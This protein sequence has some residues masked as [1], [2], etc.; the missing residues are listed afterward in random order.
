MVIKITKNK[1]P[2]AAVLKITNCSDDI[3]AILLNTKASYLTDRT[4]QSR[5]D[6]NQDR[7]NQ[8]P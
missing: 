1:V 7:G 4:P 3:I 5:L 2:A 6:S 8:N